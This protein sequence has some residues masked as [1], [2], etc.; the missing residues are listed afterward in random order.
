MTIYHKLVRDKIPTLILQEG[1]TYH[2]HIASGSEL[3]EALLSK[4]DEEVRE[5]R[6]SKDPKEL[7]DILEVV[8]R[9]AHCHHVTDEELE[10]LRREKEKEK[11][12]FYRGIILESVEEKES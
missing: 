7:A 4:L 10:A 1:K 5:F 6:A 3:E 9:L 2:A 8:Y 11:G 12:A